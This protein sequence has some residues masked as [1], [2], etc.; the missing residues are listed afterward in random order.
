MFKKSLIAV[1]CFVFAF[2]MTFNAFAQDEANP[3][4]DEIEEVT[5]DSESNDLGTEAENTREM[6]TAEETPAEDA[7]V[8]TTAELAKTYFD[9]V[10]TYVN[11]KVKFKLTTRDNFYADK[12]LYKIN[13]GTETEYTSEFNLNEEGKQT[14]TYYGVDKIG[15]K[16]DARFFRAFVD[17]TAPAVTVSPSEEIVIIDG[18][19]YTSQMNMFTINAVDTASGVNTIHYTLNGTDFSEYATTFSFNTTGDTT[20]KCVAED[21]VAN[22]SA[23]FKIMLPSENGQSVLVEKSDVQ[24]FVDNTKPTVKISSDKEFLIRK[25]KKVASRDFKYTVTAEDSESG[26]KD[27]LFRVDGKGNFVPYEKAIEFSTNGNH[28]IEAI[29]VDKVGNKSDV[30]ILSLYIDII[31]PNSQITTISDEDTEDDSAVSN[32]N[33]TVDEQPADEENVNTDTETTTDEET[34]NDTETADEEVEPVE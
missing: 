10:N 15:N 16:E 6:E 2:A 28:F 34:N 26:V 23:S 25:G 21:N 18:K 24:I 29:A 1:F 27:L 12:I 17:N 31:P 9:G 22:K 8:K 5:D 14:I 11:S 7:A 32:A 20:F 13:D 33:E 4:A 3:P 19:Y 30:A